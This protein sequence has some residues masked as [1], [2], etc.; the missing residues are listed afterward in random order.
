MYKITISAHVLPCS[1]D[2]NISLIIGPGDTKSVIVLDGFLD[3]VLGVRS[4][5]EHLWLCSLQFLVDFGNVHLLLI[6]VGVE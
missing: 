5:V 3:V 4:L 1:Q 6:G 2:G